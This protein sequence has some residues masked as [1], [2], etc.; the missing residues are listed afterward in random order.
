MS[1]IQ[2]RIR[3]LCVDDHSFLVDGLRARFENERD[4]EFVG[5]LLSADH[6]PQE[7]KKQQAEVVLVDIEMPGRDPFEAI[8]DM[9]H[10]APDVRAIILSAYIRDHY[11]S[12]AVNAGA[13]GYFSKSDEAA[14]IIEGIRTVARGKF[15]FGPKV[16]ERCQPA[17]GAK[18]GEVKPPE[19]RLD[20]LTAREQEVLRLIG[21]GLTRSEIAEILHRSPKTI[22]GHR[23]AIME[24]LDIHDRGELVRFALREGL[25]EL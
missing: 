7:A 23:E 15:A 20:A 19:S 14:D 8:E 3:V 18:R 10:R 24:K 16:L 1:A 2:R 4:I 5:S 17:A 22:D 9:K 21:K 12:A 13:W 25:A 6:L 11:I